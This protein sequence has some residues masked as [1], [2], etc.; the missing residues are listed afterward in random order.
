M[1]TYDLKLILD[2]GLKRMSREEFFARVGGNLSG[3]ELALQ[4]LKD[5]FKQKNSE[6]IEFGLGAGDIFG[7]PREAIELLKHLY[8]ADWQSRH[9][10][11]VWA[12]DR[13]RD[14]Q[15]V[16]FFYG[17]TQV[18]PTDL[19]WDYNRALA[20]K[21]IYALGNIGSGKARAYLEEIS[22]SDH[23]RL[24][25]EASNQLLRLDSIGQ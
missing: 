6:Y 13:F 21:A 24:R 12:L 25:T 20:V 2:L 14:S 1:S 11:I 7:L 22:K 4:A 16:D 10:D 19:L 15:L 3:E 23:P 18:T 5:G 9:E 8:E 17:A